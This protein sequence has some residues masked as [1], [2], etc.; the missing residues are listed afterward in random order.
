MNTSEPDIIFQG[1]CLLADKAV[2]IFFVYE[3]SAISKIYEEY[4]VGLFTK[5]Y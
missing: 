1:L 2:V 4:F 3:L 5:A